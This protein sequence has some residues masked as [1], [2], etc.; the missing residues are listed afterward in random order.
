MSKQGIKPRDGYTQGHGFHTG[1]ICREG[2]R[3]REK[4]KSPYYKIFGCMQP[5]ATSGKAPWS[6]QGDPVMEWEKAF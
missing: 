1:D 6:H 3:E 2:E 5:Q 4:K